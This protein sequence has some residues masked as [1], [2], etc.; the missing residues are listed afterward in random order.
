METKDIGYN[1]T[2]SKQ[3]AMTGEVIQ[4]TTNLHIGASQDELTAEIQKITGALD[5]RMEGVN[6]KVL[7]RTAEKLK[8]QG[9]DDDLIAKVCGPEAAEHLID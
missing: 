7:E 3:T 1:L 8:Q 5:S 9:Y 4:I 2:V 6:T